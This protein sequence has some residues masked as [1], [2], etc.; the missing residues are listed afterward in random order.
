M[1]GDPNE[2]RQAEQELDNLRIKES[3]HI[4]LYIADF[5]SLMSRIGDW[6]ERAYMHNY[7]RGLASR[8]L[9]QLAS[10][11]WSFYTLQELKDI[12]LELDTR[13]HERQKEK[14]CHPE[15]NHPVT[16][17]NFSRPPPDSSSKRTHHK[18]NKKGNQFHISKEKPQSALLN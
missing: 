18:K 10:Y 11:P 3:G 5:R 8:H 6:G 7:R 14:G 9:Y 17:S 2:L 16:G 13:Y 12:T 1:F 4:S 15:K